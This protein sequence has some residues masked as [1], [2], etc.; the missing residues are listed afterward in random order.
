MRQSLLNNA[1]AIRE[2]TD[3][4]YRTRGGLKDSMAPCS[5]TA[6]LIQILALDLRN[7]GNM[8][9][10]LH[11]SAVPK[12]VWRVHVQMVLQLRWLF[13][14]SVKRIKYR[15]AEMAKLPIFRNRS[16]KFAESDGFTQVGGR[17]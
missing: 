17:T 12:Y 3:N 10:N 13:T 15:L 8:T 5:P 11:L 4:T 7:Y 9:A 1:L 2:A 16:V 6:K 14:E